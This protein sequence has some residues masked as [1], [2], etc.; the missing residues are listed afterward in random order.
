MVIRIPGTSRRIGF[1]PLRT[2]ILLVLLVP[3]VWGAYLLVDLWRVQ[4]KIHQDLPPEARGAITEEAAA[5]T[6]PVLVFPTPR[7]KPS[8][9]RPAVTGS[10]TPE[11]TAAPSDPSPSATAPATATGEATAPPQATPTRQAAPTRTASAPTAI[12]LQSAIKDWNGKKRINVLLLGLDKR[13]DEIGRSDTIII[14]TLDFEHNKAHVLSLPRDLYVYIPGFGWR[15]INA[16]Y[17]I[18]ET[19]EYSDGTGGVG[20]L[21]KTLRY[22]LGVEDFDAFAVVDF[23][24]FVE[25]VD[26]LKGIYINVPK[27]IVD[28]QYPDGWKYT[29]IVFEKGGQWMN[30]ETALK[31]ARTRHADSDFGRIR[32]QQAVMLAI[33]QR[34]STPSVLLRAPA[35]LRV[36]GNNVRTSLDLGEQIKLAR[37]GGALPKRN[38]EFFTITGQVAMIDGQSVVWADKAD[39]DRTLKRLYGPQAEL[40]RPR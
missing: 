24:A 21:M 33:Q 32:R 22:N 40:Y 38:I 30:G 39:A 6:M 3:L 16:A 28:D 34:A 25:G 26:A 11:L 2:A 14:A 27:K 18:G 36:L 31:Y 19:P 12:P 13:G 15:K 35:L 17:A 9:P 10:P 7:P 1:R 4:A 8:A 20:L 23:K 29:R 37:W 5:A